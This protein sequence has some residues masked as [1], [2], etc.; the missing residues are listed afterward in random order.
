[1]YVCICEVNIMKKEWKCS[2]I[3]LLTVC[4]IFVL[5]NINRENTC[6]YFSWEKD[7]RDVQEKSE[8]QEAYK[9]TSPWLNDN[10]NKVKK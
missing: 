6:T 9:M 10:L 8:A 4:F 7:K 2:Q 3:L 1:M 5:A